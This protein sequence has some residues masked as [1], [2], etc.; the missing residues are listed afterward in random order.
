MPAEGWAIDAVANELALA[1]DAG[2]MRSVSA[3]QEACGVG[4][5][6]LMAVLDVMRERG[7][8]VEAAP[9][10]WRQ[11]FEDE[12]APPAAEDAPQAPEAPGGMSLAE[13]EM[14]TGP[15]RAGTV[16]ARALVGEATASLPRAMADVLDAAAI[17]ALVKAGIE[18]CPVGQTFVFEVTA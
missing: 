11:P 7:S 15:G 10:E 1:R 5:E 14:R 4:H 6:D 9:G 8:A 16:P 3:L 13:A 17:G 2:E 12:V 18:S